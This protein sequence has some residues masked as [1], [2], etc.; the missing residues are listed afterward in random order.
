MVPTFRHWRFPHDNLPTSWVGCAPPQRDTTEQLTTRPI[1]TPVALLTRDVTC[2]ITNHYLGT[3]HAHIIP[4][5]EKNWFMNNGM[6]RYSTPGFG[7]DKIDDPRNGLLLRADVHTLFDQKRFAI[8]PKISAFVCHNAIP[9]ISNEVS[10]LYHNVKL[11]PLNE[12]K[13]EY[14]LAR[15]AW[16]IFPQI[17]DFIQ[18]DMKLRL[19]IYIG[20]KETQIKNFSGEEC[21]DILSRNKSRGQSSSQG[22]KRQ[23]DEVQEA[24]DAWAEEQGDYEVRGRKRRRSGEY[25]GF[26]SSWSSE[27][28]AVEALNL[29][30]NHN[31]EK[32]VSLDEVVAQMESH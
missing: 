27:K 30:L 13:I 5:S 29:A 16:T 12:I 22:T 23:R 6:S 8:I 19:C 10:N 26:D 2:R 15:F 7:L 24:E 32:D 1:T 25:C 9:E 28:T 17:Y 21:K 18:Q 3:E 31:L 20:N 4:K 11:L 14:L